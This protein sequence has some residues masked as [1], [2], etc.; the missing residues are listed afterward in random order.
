MFREGE[1]LTTILAVLWLAVPLNGAAQSAA[2]K[3][4]DIPVARPACSRRLGNLDTDRE[5]TDR[6]SGRCVRAQQIHSSSPP[7]KSGRLVRG[8]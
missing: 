7:R 3:R 2:P 1:Q 8:S 6:V 5:V 4:N